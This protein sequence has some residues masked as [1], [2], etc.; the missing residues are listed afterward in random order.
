MRAFQL[1]LAYLITKILLMKFGV[2]FC[3]QLASEMAH[4]KLVFTRFL[5]DIALLPFRF[6]RV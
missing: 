6:V 2:Y 3:K 5:N 4:R 1:K